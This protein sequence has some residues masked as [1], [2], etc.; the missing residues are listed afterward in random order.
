M[1]H[2]LLTLSEHLTSYPVLSGVRV[3][4]SLVLCVPFVDRY[5]SLC[6]FMSLRR[7]FFFDLWIIITPLPFG[8]FKHFLQIKL[9]ILDLA[10]K[11]NEN[12]KKQYFRHIV[13]FNN[14][15]LDKPHV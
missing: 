10:L 5:V 2:A 7:L 8:S 11:V 6:P 9:I 12:E 14:E 3:T 13:L 4:Q 15:Q 1:V